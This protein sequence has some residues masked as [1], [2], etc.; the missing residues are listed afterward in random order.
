M[1]HRFEVR[2]IIDPYLGP[3]MHGMIVLIGSGSTIS[4]KY[5]P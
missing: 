1:C 5:G 3:N 4:S 2:A